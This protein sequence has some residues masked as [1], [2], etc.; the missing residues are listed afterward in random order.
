MSD[1]R[2]TFEKK[3]M[4][5][6]ASPYVYLPRE[7]PLYVVEVTHADEVDPDLLQ[8]ALDRTIARMPYLADTLQIEGGAVYY[9]K[10]P[11]PMQVGRGLGLRPVADTR[12][13]VTC[14]TSPATARSRA[15]P[16]TTASAMARASTRSRSR[17]STT[18]WREGLEVPVADC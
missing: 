14:S 4:S 13:T 3:E 5:L 7:I 12:P 17:C 9:A 15:S 10:N 11:L 2:P 6:S 18:A 8:R 1:S 16:C